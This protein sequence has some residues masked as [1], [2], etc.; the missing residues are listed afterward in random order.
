[1]CHFEA[2]N[3]QFWE[4]AQKGYIY[5][6]GHYKNVNLNVHNEMGQT[7][8]M[9]AVRNGHRA[10]ID[11]FSE[12][13]VDITIQDFEGKT[14]YDYIQTFSNHPKERMASKEYGALKILEVM[15]IVR[16]KAKVVQYSYKNDT[17]FL[18]ITIKGAVCDDFTFPENTQCFATKPSS[19]HDIFK[20]I[21]A[22]D[23]MLFEQLIT[24][25]DDLSIKNKSNYSL[26]WASIHYHNLYAYIDCP[27]L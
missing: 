2:Q 15:Q 23:N 22:K 5:G 24:T 27:S 26:L 19:N 16:N 14:A 9:I 6:I 25:V 7:P 1:M 17:N 3:Q 4:D 18:Q 10:V 12:G 11:A 20:D 13:I 8:L 21:K